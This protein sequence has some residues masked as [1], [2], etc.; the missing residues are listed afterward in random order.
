MNIK[1]FLAVISLLIMLSC[2]TVSS[3]SYKESE[4]ISPI[5]M[6][7][8]GDIGINGFQHTVISMKYDSSEYLIFCAHGEMKVLKHKGPFVQGN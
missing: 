3:N 5:V 6:E 8:L 7:E 4:S 1:C 2:T